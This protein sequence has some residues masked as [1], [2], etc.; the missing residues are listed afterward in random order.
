MNQITFMKEITLELKNKIDHLI[1]LSSGNIAIC[2]GEY[3]FIYKIDKNEFKL[4]Q[5]IKL[6]I[7]KRKLRS[8]YHYGKKFI[9]DF[10]KA[11][12]IEYKNG[13][14]L[15]VLKRIPFD[16]SKYGLYNCSSI[17]DIFS[18]NEKESYS[19]IKSVK[20]TCEVKGRMLYN[21]NNNY[22]II[23]GVKGAN[24]M[25]TSYGVYSF[26][27]EKQEEKELNYMSYFNEKHK[28]FFISDNKVLHYYTEFNTTT[29][30]IYN[31]GKNNEIISKK[32]ENKDNYN[33]DYLFN[34]E[35]YIYFVLVKQ[36]DKFNEKE[37]NSSNELTFY[38][39]DYN[40]ELIEEAKS[41]YNAKIEYNK[42]IKVQS[43]LILY[44]NNETVI[45]KGVNSL[46]DKS[47]KNMI[48]EIFE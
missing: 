20:F 38:K 48:S 37:L 3:V 2:I 15:L 29:I 34:N 44:G 4:I 12:C 14:F 26:D 31:L 45:L 8:Y 33:I 32:K 39:Y 43:N 18:L 10:I 36:K 42:V 22:L 27:L 11:K 16:D 9:P 6:S 1:I 30:N 25:T 7:E 47:G 13:K 41:S 5:K 21:N 35:K 40:L 23:H 24:P 19:F 46:D 28:L 17:I